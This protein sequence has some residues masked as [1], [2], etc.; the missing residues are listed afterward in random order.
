LAVCAVLAGARSFVA[1]AEWAADAGESTSG[2]L[3]VTGRVPS[4]STFRRVLQSLDAGALD[5]AA[6]VWV[7]PGH[8]SGGGL[9]APGLTANLAPIPALRMSQNRSSEDTHDCR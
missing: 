8:D 3:G 6:G 1:I 9:N 7:Q 5:D 4:E 2:E